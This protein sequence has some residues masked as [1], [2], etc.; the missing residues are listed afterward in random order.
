MSRLGMEVSTQTQFTSFPTPYRPDACSLHPGMEVVACGSIEVF[1]GSMPGLHP[2]QQEAAPAGP[3]R[4]PTPPP[5]PRQR[6][7]GVSTPAMKHT[8]PEGFSGHWLV[9]PSDSPV[10]G[11]IPVTIMSG[12]TS[13]SF[14]ESEVG[15]A[16]SPAPLAESSMGMVFSPGP[17]ALPVRHHWPRAGV[18][19]ISEGPNLWFESQKNTQKLASR[20][21]MYRVMPSF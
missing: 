14:I 12:S 21:Q 6:H 7:R 4:T 18:S 19:E 20:S 9:L 10:S 15:A 16:R 17:G 11:P 5:V 8:P 3:P 2:G 1:R 13:E